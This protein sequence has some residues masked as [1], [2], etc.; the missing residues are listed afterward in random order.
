VVRRTVG[1][2]AFLPLAARAPVYAGL[3]VDLVADPRVPVARKAALAGAAG[4]LLLGRDLVPDE[5]PLLGGLDDLIVLLI[6][7]NVF[8]DGVPADVL[9]ERLGARG[10]DKREFLRDVAQ[11]RRLTPRPIRIAIRRFVELTDA[12]RG[13]IR[14]SGLGRAVR[15]R[16]G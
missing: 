10:I 13:I 8:L 11:V 3:V 4:Y 16:I 6:A 12:T 9:D 1:Y 5:L 7:V 14:R 15:S 2:L